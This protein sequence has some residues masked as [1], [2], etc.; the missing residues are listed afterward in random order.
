MSS[1]KRASSPTWNSLEEPF[2]NS[3]SLH[4]QHPFVLKSFNTQSWNYSNLGFSPEILWSLNGSHFLTS[5]HLTPFV[6]LVTIFICPQRV[7]L[8]TSRPHNSDCRFNDHYTLSPSIQS[9]D[10]FV[11]VLGSCLMFPDCLAFCNLHSFHH[12][13]CLVHLCFSTSNADPPASSRINRDTSFFG[14]LSVSLLPGIPDWYLPSM[15]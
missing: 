13:E 10:A 9:T 11:P 6:Y 2:I 1:Q 14:L 7:N 4:R 8:D 3:S 5:H 15:S 12:W